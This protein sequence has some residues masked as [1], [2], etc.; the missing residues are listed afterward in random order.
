MSA[1]LD[2]ATEEFKDTN[3]NKK[4]VEHENSINSS[5]NF[6]AHLKMAR[7]PPLQDEQEEVQQGK[8]S[9]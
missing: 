8:R 5:K 1:S 6:K 3:V 9:L 2:K 4:E 7:Q